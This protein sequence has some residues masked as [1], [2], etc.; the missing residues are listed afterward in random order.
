MS[1]NRGWNGGPLYI[2]SLTLLARGWGL[3]LASKTILT[4]A[5]VA[6][7]LTTCL[8]GICRRRWDLWAALVL[9]WL[10]PVDT[11]A[12]S[13]HTQFSGLCFSWV[14]AW[15]SWAFST[16]HL[17][18]IGQLGTWKPWNTYFIS[19]ITSLHN[20]LSKFRAHIQLIAL[21]SVLYSWNVKEVQFLLVS[22]L[23]SEGA[24]AVCVV[25]STMNKPMWFP[26]RLGLLVELCT[27]SLF[28]SR[29][30]CRCH[31]QVWGELGTLHLRSCK[32]FFHAS[33]HT[34]PL[35][36]SELVSL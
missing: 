4:F 20:V 28:G 36:I 19:P 15:C 23:P 8:W 12:L 33:A 3:A 1:H 34:S 6:S 5:V 9:S 30:T 13:S 24:C 10:C 11:H 29:S 17:I 22:C 7:S 21:P 27:P 2:H 25:L 26:R 18:C 35:A 32:T 14:F 31:L 16:C